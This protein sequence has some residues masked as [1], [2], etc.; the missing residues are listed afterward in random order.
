LDVLLTICIF[1]A[2]LKIMKKFIVIIV[3]L[4]GLVG[5]SH[6]PSVSYDFKALKDSLN[7][8]SNCVFVEECSPLYSDDNPYN[9]PNQ[10]VRVKTLYYYVVHN[11]Q[12]LDT[13]IHAVFR[14][15]QIVFWG[16]SSPKKSARE[17][18]EW[19]INN[20]DKI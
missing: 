7:L 13:I 11:D 14:N 12:G 1:A 19:T 8:A 3:V 2:K 5:C 4:L 16:K 17:L 15:N 20:R 18:I 9:L 6:T 10:E